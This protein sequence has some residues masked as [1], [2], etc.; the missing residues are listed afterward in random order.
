MGLEAIV[1]VLTEDT[2]TVNLVHSFVMP[3]VDVT[4]PHHISADQIEVT[5]A[6]QSQSNPIQLNLIVMTKRLGNEETY[7]RYT[8]PRRRM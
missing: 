7:E 5:R 4:P 3:P 2:D 8:R 1:I 6:E